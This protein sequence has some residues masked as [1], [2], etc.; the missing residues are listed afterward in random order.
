[1]YRCTG[2]TLPG[3]FGTVGSVAVAV[4]LRYGVGLLG[5]RHWEH[6]FSALPQ[7]KPKP[8]VYSLEGTL[9]H[10]GGGG[11]QVHCRKRV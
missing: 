5:M 1:M 4:G 6:S 2:L 3:L 8:S 9:L 11:D 7:N 10:Y